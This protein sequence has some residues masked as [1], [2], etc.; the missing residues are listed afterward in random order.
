MN[1]LAIK[2]EMFEILAQTHDEAL[3]L[4]FYKTMKEVFESTQTGWW[5]DL[6]F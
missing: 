2:V 5:D 6:P 1:A 4:K 3:L